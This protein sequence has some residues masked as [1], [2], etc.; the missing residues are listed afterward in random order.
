MS[1]YYNALKCVHC[2]FEFRTD[3]YE[4]DDIW[5]PECGLSQ[6][7]DAAKKGVWKI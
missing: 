2:A 4:E 1:K 3:G 6:N 5:C 7:E